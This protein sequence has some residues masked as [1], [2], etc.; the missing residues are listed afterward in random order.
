[1]KVAEA[2]VLDRDHHRDRPDD[3]RHDAQDVLRARRCPVPGMQAFLQGIEGAGSDVAEHHPDRAEDERGCARASRW[4][5]RSSAFDGICHVATGRMHQNGPERSHHACGQSKTRPPTS[6]PDPR[7][8]RPPPYLEL[9]GRLFILIEKAAIPRPS[10]V[11]LPELAC[12]ASVAR[13]LLPGSTGTGRSLVPRP[14]A[15]CR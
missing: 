13:N 8:C 14:I 10:A 2:K 6:G 4:P 12:I 7:P 3:Q 5:S 9:N 15:T 11:Q 1:M